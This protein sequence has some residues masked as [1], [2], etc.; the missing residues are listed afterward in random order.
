MNEKNSELH[1]VFP[2]PIWTS[3]IDDYENINKKLYNF[4][5]SHKKFN[6][7]GIVKKKKKGWHSKNF[8]LKNENVIFF[9]NSISSKIKIAMEDMGWDEPNN[10]IEISNMWSI[11]NSKGSSNSMHMHSNCYLSAAYYVKA[12]KNCGEIVFHDHR[13]ARLVRKP[14]TKKINNLNTEEVKIEPKDGLLVLFPNYLYHSVM[15]NISDDERIVI[16]FNVDIK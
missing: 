15:Q 13:Q 14:K 3:V 12:P 11:I 2:T 9:V 6:E 4:I 10:K 8:E 7:N 1:L 16:S 5:Y